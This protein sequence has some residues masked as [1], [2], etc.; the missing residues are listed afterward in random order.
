VSERHRLGQWFT[1]EPV[2]DLALA[3]AGALPAGARILDP[4]CGDGAF[5]AGVAR[6][7]PTAHRL[8]VE[9]DPAA[10]EAAANR[11]PGAEI[12]VD[13]LFAPGIAGRLGR[14]DAVVG[15]PPWVRAD[16]MH[17]AQRVR[18]GEALAAWPATASD[19]AALV[20][21]ADLA[22]ACLLRGLSLLAPG[23]RLAL[24]LS[25]ALLD[26]DYAA[27]L[28]RA[29]MAV[30]RPV[31]VLAAPAERW[32]A[33]AAVNAMIVVLERH[34]GDVRV[35]DDVP[36]VVT[37]ARL[38]VPTAEA[39]ARIGR[40]GLAA[41][42]EVRS[43]PAADPARWAAALRAPAAW[44]RVVEA[45]GD[46]LV[47]LSALA[48]IRRGVTSGANDVFYLKRAQAAELG[49]E[50]AALAP[51]VRSPY[52]GSPAPIAIDPVTTPLVALALPPRADLAAMPRVAAWIARHAP[53]AT[54]PSLA[55]REPWWSLPVRPARLFLAKAYGPRFVQ[56]LAPVP[57]I[58]DQRV[59]AV[60]PRPGVGLEVLAA[61][62]N[63]TW[64]A[65]A[66]EALGRAS[67]G[68]GALEWTVADA[69]Q[70]PVLDVR[71]ATPA[72]A[73]ALVAA[74]AAMMERE[75][76]HVALERARADRRALDLAAAGLA[77]GLEE[78]LDAVWTELL[79]AV[80][81]RDRWLLP[82]L[83]A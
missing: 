44:F 8:G 21:R 43:A 68:H 25:T 59:Y 58:G 37:V 71:R 49:L 55:G 32:F 38:T 56:R 65:L 41:V 48:E 39:A 74:L 20:A 36:D 46:A 52:N 63:A 64:T 2:V 19:R 10:A 5:L 81:L 42:A 66:L 34:V 31:L 82:A 47:P 24:V 53:A 69:Q 51:L 78:Q 54:R 30:A 6:H 26:A 76:E 16:R 4:A 40:D 9:V 45:A 75:I 62:L 12:V 60:E 57:V 83:S 67:M 77:P 18:I 17:A 29:A 72:Q 70:L 23:G 14:I 79:A 27:P 35:P 80:R 3:L 7:H 28:W 33:E 11:A 50:A 1:P 13:D 15:N 22:A 61:V 73:A